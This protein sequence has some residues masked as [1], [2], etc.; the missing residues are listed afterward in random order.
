MVDHSSLSLDSG[1][2][3]Q[4]MS[5]QR[6]LEEESQHVNEQ[7]EEEEARCDSADCVSK[8]ENVEMIEHE[9]GG[10]GGGGDEPTI[11]KF[12]EGHVSD[13]DAEVERILGAQGEKIMQDEVTT[14]EEKEEEEEQREQENEDEKGEQQGYDEVGTM[15]IVDKENEEMLMGEISLEE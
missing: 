5:Q 12:K 11:K 1:F 6:Q 9:E 3:D 7:G 14:R 2:F 10:G 8:S 15:R 4:I 13:E